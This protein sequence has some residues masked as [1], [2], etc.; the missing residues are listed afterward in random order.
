M[1]RIGY[2]LKY[3][4]SEDFVMKFSTMLRFYFRLYSHVEIYLK[5]L[6]SNAV[7]FSDFLTIVAERGYSC[8]FHFP[9]NVLENEE[10]FSL[11]QS[12]L[13]LKILKNYPIIV[14]YHNGPLL[15]RLQELSNIIYLENEAYDNLDEFQ[16]YKIEISELYKRKSNIKM[17]LDLGHLMKTLLLSNNYSDKVLF[18]FIAGIEK[19]CIG[20]FHIHGVRGE[21]DH[22]HLRFFGEN[23]KDLIRNIALN[24]GQVP[25][26]LE[27]KGVEIFSEGKTQI[28]FFSDNDDI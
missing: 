25:F 28:G 2:K 10:V 23:P 11:F 21:K 26:V 12:F 24:F 19:D 9:N 7:A 17:C 4:E 5:A 3:E 18:D 16:Q 14:H 8:S 6:P 27:T 22:A 13:N 1:N 20:E 15:Q